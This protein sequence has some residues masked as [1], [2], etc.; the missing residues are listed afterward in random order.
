MEV[1]VVEQLGAERRRLSHHPLP[2]GVVAEAERGPLGAAVDLGPLLQH[3]GEALARLVRRVV[4]A[5]LAGDL[6]ELSGAVGPLAPEVGVGRR[7]GKVVDVGLDL[8][9]E[10]GAV[11]VGEARQVERARG[12]LPRRGPGAASSP[13]RASACRRR[14]GSCPGRTSAPVA[15]VWWGRTP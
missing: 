5:H 3:L 10:L 9:G 6:E 15:E 8:L 2:V 11:V 12:L 7:V 1:V 13:G 14:W 4:G